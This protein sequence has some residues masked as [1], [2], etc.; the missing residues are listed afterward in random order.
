MNTKRACWLGL[1]IGLALGALQLVRLEALPADFDKDLTLASILRDNVKWP[2]PVM[3]R[4]THRV[5]VIQKGLK[6]GH[7]DLPP[8]LM[9][10]AESLS[11]DGYLLVKWSDLDIKL[12]F[13]KTD[14]YWRA[15][16]P[17]H[18]GL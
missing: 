15:T 3:L 6:F 18:G 5:H 1:F 7:V 16:S 17:G 12:P 8:G 9:L 2:C 10:T 11:D 14:F 4:E 13:E